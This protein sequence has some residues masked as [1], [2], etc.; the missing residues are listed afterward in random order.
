MRVSRFTAEASL[1]KTSERYCPVGAVTS[2][3]FHVVPALI[4]NCDYACAD[5]DACQELFGFS[6]LQCAAICR[7]C[8]VC[9][10]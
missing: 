5:C 3:T 7:L 1:Y 4:S 2:N 9:P 8:S 6:S 10:V